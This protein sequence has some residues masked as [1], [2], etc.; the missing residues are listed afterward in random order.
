MEHATRRAMGP[1]HAEIDS[2]ILRI[3][4]G[5][6]LVDDGNGDMPVLAG[7]RGQVSILL[8]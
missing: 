7:V 4:R 6:R 8:V 5:E 3:I 2:L 1:P